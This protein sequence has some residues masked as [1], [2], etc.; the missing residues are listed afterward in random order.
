MTRLVFSGIMD[1]YPNLKF[2][3]HHCGAMR[4]HLADRINSSYEYWKITG[5]KFMESMGKPPI[6]YF[7]RFYNDTALYGNT[8]AL[9][10]LCFIRSRTHTLWY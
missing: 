9:M 6:E 2:I 1:K 4:P 7:R 3:T 8:P 10:R 5:A